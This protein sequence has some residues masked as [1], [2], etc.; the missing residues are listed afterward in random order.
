MPYRLGAFSGV[1]LDEALLRLVI[2]EHTSAAL[3][4]LERL[5]TYYRNPAEPGGMAGR[6]GGGTGVSPVHVYRLGQEQGL[7]S[8]L[9]GPRD[10]ATDDRRAARREV[11][12][13]NDIAWRVQAMVDFMFGKPV[14]ILSTA[15]DEGARRTIERI[16][17]AVWEAS[18]GIALLQDMALLGHVYGHVD[19]VLREGTAFGYPHASRGAVSEVRSASPSGAPGRAGEIDPTSIA[20]AVRIEAIDPTRAIPILDPADYRRLLAYIIHFERELNEVERFGAS[21]RPTWRSLL[22]RAW[23]AP[24][25]RRATSTLTEILSADRTQAYEDESLVADSPGTL[26]P[27]VLP[28]VHMQNISQPLHYEGVGEVEPLIPLQDELNTRL[29]DRANRVTMQ[30]FR[31]YLAKGVDGF[32]RAS[33][34]PGAIWTSDTPPWT[35]RSSPSAATPTRPARRC[36]ISGRRSSRRWPRRGKRRWC[37]PSP[38]HPGSLAGVIMVHPDP[39]EGWPDHLGSTV[40]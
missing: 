5:W 34:E 6:W 17:D 25:A 2:D 38:N 24:A 21:P 35:P 12:I 7:P 27:G 19:L 28:V 15:R 18:G 36:T 8:R 29:S 13:E 23:R 14:T 37:E 33:V 32:D 22:A 39:A 40:E 4:R 10:P 16:L 20:D 9:V 11:V 31:M 1:G 30:S 26:T 3:P